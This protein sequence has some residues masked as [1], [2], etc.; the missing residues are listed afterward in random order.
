MMN[1]IDPVWFIGL[2]YIVKF[3]FEQILVF[4]NFTEGITNKLIGCYQK[5]DT[6]K[7][8]GIVMRIY[9]AQTDLIIDREMEIRNMQV[10]A[11]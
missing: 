10:R 3:I 8:D 1:C 7:E 11:H 6:E 5:T 4:Q 9:G 2:M